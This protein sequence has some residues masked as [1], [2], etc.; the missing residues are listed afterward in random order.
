PHDYRE[1]SPVQ[2]KDLRE[3][4]QSIL[5]KIENA[6]LNR[7]VRTILKKFDKEFYEFPAAKTNTPANIKFSLSCG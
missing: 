1:S 4:V 6:T 5:F 7:I 3:Y 2:E